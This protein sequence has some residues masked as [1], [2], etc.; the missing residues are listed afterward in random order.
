MKIK[1][2]KTN[3]GRYA[4][5]V[6]K[7]NWKGYLTSMYL[8]QRIE[9][10]YPYYNHAWEAYSSG[11]RMEKEL[12]FHMNTLEKKADYETPPMDVSAEETLVGHYEDTYKI[13]LT[14]VQT[15]QGQEDDEEEAYNGLKIVIIELDAV[16]EN[17]PEEE[18]EDSEELERLKVLVKAFKQLRKKYYPDKEA[19]EAAEEAA[20]ELVDPMAPPMAPSMAPMAPMAAS[21]KIM[22]LVRAQVRGSDFCDDQL[23]SEL[24]QSYAEK[25]CAA[26]EPHFKDV[27]FESNPDDSE[28]ILYKAAKE[29]IP[30]IKIRI[31]DLLHVDSIVPTGTLYQISPLHSVEFYQKCWKPIVEEIGNF[32]VKDAGVLLVPGLSKLPNIPKENS[33]EAKVSGW[34]TEKGSAEEVGM[35]F[36]G[37]GNSSLWVFEPSRVERIAATEKSKVSKYVEEDYLNGIFKCTDPQLESIYERTGAVIQVIPHTDFLEVDIDF[38]KGIDVVRLTEDKIEKVI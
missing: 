28:I 21:D 14:D 12:G 27:V 34:N 15:A 11:R 16:I 35:S 36:Q 10:I 31:N 8:S 22:R 18:K 17:W 9:S 7:D 19:E 25:A 13:I 38:G 32:F 26:I 23:K 24:L 6:A 3:D 5:S 4:F 2:L 29:L 20:T 1:L 33:L 37:E 30:L